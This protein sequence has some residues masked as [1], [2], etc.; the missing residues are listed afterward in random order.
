MIK[1]DI[2]IWW[3]LD[4]RDFDIDAVGESTARRNVLAMCGKVHELFA[5]LI[6]TA[7]RDEHFHEVDL[8]DDGTLVLR[9]HVNQALDQALAAVGVK[10]TDYA[11]VANDV[12]GKFDDLALPDAGPGGN[13]DIVVTFSH[14]ATTTGDP[15]PYYYQGPDGITHCVYDDILLVEGEPARLTQWN[16][17]EGV[18]DVFVKTDF[19]VIP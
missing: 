11:A 6:P 5:K 12:V 18:A 10:R 15:V 19:V 3:N 8:A 7:A 14:E 17:Y 2:S 13:D 4:G 16:T 9:E 1:A